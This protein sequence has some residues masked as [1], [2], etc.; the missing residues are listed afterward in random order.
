[1]CSIDRD[2]ESQRHEQVNAW[3]CARPTTHHDLVSGQE[4]VKIEKDRKGKMV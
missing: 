2:L 4:E 1:M 3:M